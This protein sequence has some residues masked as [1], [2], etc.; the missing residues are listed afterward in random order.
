[1]KNDLQKILLNENDIRKRIQELGLEIDRHYEGREILLVTLLDGAIVFAADLIRNLSSPLRL[2][3]LRV[4]SYG[5]STD[6]ETAP[7]ILSSLKSEVEGKDVLL[8]D[9]IL[10]TGNTMQRVS[11]EVLS[12]NPASLKTC[13]FLDKPDR[14]Q[15]HFRATWSGF[16]IPDEFVVGY[17]LDYAGQYRQLPYVGTLKPSIYE[18]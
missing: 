5:N 6:P 3:C 14:R 7:R 11:E 9:D 8:V 15:N 10:D 18:K 2:D 1:M 4:S 17:G 12:K 13:V 16:F